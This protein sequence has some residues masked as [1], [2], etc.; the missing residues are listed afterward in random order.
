MDTLLNL[1]DRVVDW[2]RYD[3][4]RN[5]YYKH[6]PSLVNNAELKLRPMRRQDIDAVFGIE[7]KAYEFPW[8]LETFR[9]CYRVGYHCWVGEKARQ[10]VCYGISTVGADESHILNVCVDPTY[11]G[12]G[13]GRLMLRQLVSIA[14]RCGAGTV[15]LEVR[16][17]NPGAIKLYR[18]E[19]F[20]DLG[21]RRDYYPARH[22]REHAI[23]MA[24]TL[25]REDFP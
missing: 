13:Y 7:G 15:F 10:I 11:Q 2:V 23:V 6:F 24:K 17:S 22:G 16:P 19:G 4:E 5:F 20:N 21:T 25:F 18:S 3:A 1:V 12:K 8:E 9:S 14:Q